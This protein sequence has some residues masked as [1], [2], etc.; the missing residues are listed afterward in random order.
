[1]CS[2]ARPPEYVVPGGYEP[3]ES[4]RRRMRQEHEATLRYQQTLEAERLQNF[5]QLLRLEQEVLVPNQESME[6][7][8]CFQHVP[9]GQGV[10]LREC[11]H[12]FCRYRAEVPSLTRCWVAQLVSAE[13]YRRFLE[14]SLVQ[15]ERRTQNSFHCKTPDCRGWCVYD[16]SANEFRCPVCGVLNCLRCKVSRAHA[17]RHAGTHWDT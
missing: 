7:R 12:N 11:L 3:D 1:M 9:A 15:A 13:E 6:C 17:V 8:I 4:E 16:D 10:L 5:Q 14:R 2:A